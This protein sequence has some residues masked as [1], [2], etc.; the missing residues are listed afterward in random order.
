MDG[1]KTFN[2]INIKKL[3]PKMQHL[4]PNIL[5]IFSI[6]VV[7]ILLL[8]SVKFS[9]LKTVGI[10]SSFYFT[11]HPCNSYET[12]IAKNKKNK[13]CAG[14]EQPETVINATEK[15][16][17]EAVMADFKEDYC[18][19]RNIE[20][21]EGMQ[22]M[23]YVCR[24]AYLVSSNISNIIIKGLYDILNL[25]G[26]YSV[27]VLI[28]YIGMFLLLK[29]FRELIGKFIPKIKIGKA[30]SSF[31]FDIFFSVFSIT[32]V[33]YVVCLI[34]TIIIYLLYLVYG[35]AFS[36]G[37]GA[38]N[39]LR[40]MYFI[41]IV[42]IPISLWLV[43]ASLNIQEGYRGRKSVYKP[44]SHTVGPKK[45]WASKAST[46]K[47]STYKAS[48]AKKAPP[49]KAAPK[50][51]VA[52]G[53]YNWIFFISF[54][55][56]IP[57]MACLKQIPFL[58]I[59]G[60]NGLTCISKMKTDTP[61]QKADKANIIKKISFVSVYGILIFVGMIIFPVIIHMLRNVTVHIKFKFLTDLLNKLED[62]IKI[63]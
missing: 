11:L 50:K 58:I 20:D 38:T 10:M 57:V 61:E 36:D 8:L 59:N 18:E 26:I 17:I 51:A 23:L 12:F 25:K 49:K 14:I 45:S 24:A 42:I 54:V 15:E 55:L 13:S 31:I 63:K 41:C 6:G 21:L 35:F 16:T 2:I 29:F 32:T 53:D 30:K 4:V 28:L 56:V 22:P 9:D 44:T 47:A 39:V 48:T 7:I 34:P 5:L 62:L 43:G 19:K 3:I 37:A 1:L 46:Y 27:G 60:I 40:T 33:V 52:C